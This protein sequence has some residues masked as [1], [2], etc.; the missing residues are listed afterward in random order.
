MDHATE[1]STLR[2]QESEKEYS[3]KEEKSAEKGENNERE[4]EEHDD[5][6]QLPSAKQ[7]M[8]SF[9]ESKSDTT[10]EDKNAQHTLNAIN[11]WYRAP[12]PGRGTL[13][14][15]QLLANSFTGVKKLGVLE[16]NPFHKGSSSGS[17]SPD[18]F[19]KPE[20]RT[21]SSPAPENFQSFIKPD[22]TKSGN[23][24]RPTP[25]VAATVITTICRSIVLNTD[26]FL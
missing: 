14:R 25:V 24:I 5:N 3:E 16:V 12:S 13:G 18:F 23:L 4:E 20:S 22:Q 10:S 6:V 11:D 7:L 21:S 26:N 9:D 15:S 17:P 8:S 19:A 1:H 2:S